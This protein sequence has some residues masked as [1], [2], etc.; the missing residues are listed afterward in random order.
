MHTIIHPDPDP[1]YY[2]VYSDDMTLYHYGELFM[3]NALITGLDHL[4]QFTANEVD[5]W[6]A[7]VL[8][9]FGTNLVLEN[10]EWIEEE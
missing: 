8:E 1:I 10:G 5:Q 9:L 3:D 6:V 2:I 4:E 7:R